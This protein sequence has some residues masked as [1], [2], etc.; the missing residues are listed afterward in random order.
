MVLLLVLTPV[1]VPVADLMPVPVR[2]WAVASR[3][4]AHRTSSAH[5]CTTP[6]AS[7]PPAA[8]I[9]G[10]PQPTS[11][12]VRTSGPAVRATVTPVP[13]KPGLPMRSAGARSKP[14]CQVPADRRISATT[15]S[16]APSTRTP[17]ATH[18]EAPADSAKTAQDTSITNPERRIARVAEAR[19]ATPRAIRTWKTITAPVLRTN[20]AETSQAGAGL[21]DP[22]RNAQTEQRA[23]AAAARC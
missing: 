11:S 3:V 19:P 14:T 15:W 21:G 13:K 22:Q 9:P 5:P 16:T 12:A 2:R 23:S 20:N 1:L 10:V 17:A 4:A 6:P 18:G 7:V 8:A